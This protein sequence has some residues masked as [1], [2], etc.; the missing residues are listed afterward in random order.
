MRQV[1]CLPFYFVIFVVLFF[2]CVQG[3]PFVCKCVYVCQ[4]QCWCF[5]FLLFLSLSLSSISFPVH[6]VAVCYRCVLR[7]PVSFENFMYLAPCSV[8]IL[9]ACDVQTV[10]MLI[11]WMWHIVCGG[12]NTEFFLWWLSSECIQKMSLNNMYILES[13]KNHVYILRWERNE[14]MNWVHT[15]VL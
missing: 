12:L 14:A 6:I 3:K 15:L 1:F 9:N 4:I 8:K 2:V 10:S 7:L 13:K 5:V 11:L